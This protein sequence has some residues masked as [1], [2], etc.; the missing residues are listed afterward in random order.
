MPTPEKNKSE[1][2]LCFF[3]F[4]SSFV[5]GYTIFQKNVKKK[6][7]ITPYGR[8]FLR[9]CHLSGGIG[10]AAAFCQPSDGGVEYE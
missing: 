2:L 3:P 4:L 1:N 10:E 5:L 9:L 8:T 6:W 7:R